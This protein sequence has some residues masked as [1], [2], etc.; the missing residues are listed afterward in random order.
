MF[1][2]RLS[3]EKSPNDKHPVFAGS[4]LGAAG[5]SNP[6]PG[7]RTITFRSWSMRANLG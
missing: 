1:V 7:A 5:G 3:D 2:N 4:S 6:T